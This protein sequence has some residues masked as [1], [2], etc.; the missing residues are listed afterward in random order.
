MKTDLPR[1]IYLK[2]YA[3][4]PYLIS[5]TELDVALTP[6]QTA[7]K[8]R[9]WLSPNPNAKGRKHSLKLDGELLKLVRVALYG[10]DLPASKYVVTDKDLTINTV[11]STP[12]TLEIE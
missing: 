1:T 9:L 8:A 6:S 2:D 4:P 11:P 7:V 12:F 3:P 10:E 5:N